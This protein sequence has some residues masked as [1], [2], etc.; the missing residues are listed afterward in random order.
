MAPVAPSSATV[1][2]LPPA[3]ARD[4][5]R[6]VGGAP[7][8]LLA[9]LGAVGFVAA[10][11]GQPPLVAAVPVVGGLVAPEGST[12]VLMALAV[13]VLMVCRMWRRNGGDGGNG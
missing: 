13:L 5:D 6:S 4:R 2:V 7:W 9:P 1:P 10:G 3:V 12:R 8:A 11:G